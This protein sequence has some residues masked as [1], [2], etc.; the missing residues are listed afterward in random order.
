MNEQY[1]IKLIQEKD[2]LI[3][4]LTNK[5]I[6]LEKQMKELVLDNKRLRDIISK[7]SSNSSKPP[8]SDY[9]KKHQ[10]SEGKVLEKQEVSKVMK[11]LHLS[12]QIHL[13]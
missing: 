9:G 5:L 11:E 12:R 6:S 13:T 2:L 10:V 7:N 8:S 1:Y 3:E 4:E